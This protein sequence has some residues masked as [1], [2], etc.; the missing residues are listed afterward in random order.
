MEFVGSGEVTS[1][2]GLEKQP[3]DESL[4]EKAERPERER[5]SILERRAERRREKEGSAATPTH[6]HDRMIAADDL[7]QDSRGG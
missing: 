5:E 2:S 7:A 3:I 1:A 4:D 6:L